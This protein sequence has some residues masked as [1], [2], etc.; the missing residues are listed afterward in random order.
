MNS[1]PVFNPLKQMYKCF[2]GLS[3]VFQLVN[4]SVGSLEPEICMRNEVQQKQGLDSVSHF[5]VVL[6][7]YLSVLSQILSLEQ[8]DV[9]VS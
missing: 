8:L 5:A 3:V 6:Q 2:H 9:L 4:S 1:E 7:F